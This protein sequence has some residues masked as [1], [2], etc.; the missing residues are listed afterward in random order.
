M[1]GLSA[2]THATA[3]L[4]PSPA[5]TFD[6]FNFKLKGLV[7]I[8]TLE[9]QK[10]CYFLNVYVLVDENIKCSSNLSAAMNNRNQLESYLA[11]FFLKEKQKIFI[12]FNE[13]NR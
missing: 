7:F 8:L 10:K 2:P 5:T 11:Q 1:A 4:E 3:S 12:I 9:K 6:E 13:T